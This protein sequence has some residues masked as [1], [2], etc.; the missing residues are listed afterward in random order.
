MK[1]QHTMVRQAQ[2]YLKYRQAMGFELRTVLFPRRLRRSPEVTL[3]RSAE[4][5]HP[6][7]RIGIGG[8]GVIHA[9]GVQRCRC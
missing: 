4:V 9:A 2:A 5:T 8:G 7:N 6:W 1:R 3:L